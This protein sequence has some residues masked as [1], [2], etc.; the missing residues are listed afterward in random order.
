MKIKR[1]KKNKQGLV[2]G[3]AWYRPEQW[4]RLHEISDDADKLEKTHEAW[5]ELAESN[6]AKFRLHGLSPRKIDV[7]VEELLAWCNEHELRVDGKARAQ[8]VSEK[9]RKLHEGDRRFLLR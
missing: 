9:A 6:L 8:Y 1:R 2:V 4:Q 3:V 7:D 5:R